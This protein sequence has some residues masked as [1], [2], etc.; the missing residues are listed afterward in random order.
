LAAFY[1]ARRLVI[2]PILSLQKQMRRF[3]LGQRNPPMI[4]PPGSVLEIQ[5]AVS[6]FSKL[7]LIVARNEAALALT[8]EGKLVLLREVHHRIKNNLQMISSI[9]SIQRHKSVDS[10]VRLVLSGL[11]DRVLC[12]AAVDQSLYLNGDVGNVRA[13]F[14]ISTITDRLIGGNLEP[15]RG[16]KVTTAY[17][18]VLLHADQIG[19]LSLLA[20][21]MMTNA[22]KY[23]GQAE[24]GRSFIDIQLNWQN[25]LVVMA[26]TN[27]VG[28][29]WR[30]SDVASAGTGLGMPL[31]RALCDQLTADCQSGPNVPGYEFKLSVQFRPIGL[32]IP[33]PSVGFAV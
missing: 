12:I 5:E 30:E 8:A 31:I 3:A 11:Q 28:P 1:A 10:D 23:V 20:N 29:E 21:E 13:D 17:E 25:D 14:L 18:P 26:V 2:A 24:D 16:I 4:L 19:P 33:D 22:L 15:S 7:E 32:T 6:T 9:I 27:S